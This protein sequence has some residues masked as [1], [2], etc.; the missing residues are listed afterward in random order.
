M[1]LGVPVVPEENMTT[2]GVLKATC[3]KYS[4]VL[5]ALLE[6]VSKEMLAG[7]GRFSWF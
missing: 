6:K 7:S 2:K 3:S 5:V 4:S 1:P